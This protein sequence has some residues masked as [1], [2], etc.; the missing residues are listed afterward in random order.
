MHVSG[1]EGTHVAVFDSDYATPTSDST[2]CFR[3][4]MSTIMLLCLSIFHTNSVLDRRTVNYPSL[5][6]MW[7]SNGAMVF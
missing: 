2:D 1:F 5:V 6:N 4:K 3:H 7:Y